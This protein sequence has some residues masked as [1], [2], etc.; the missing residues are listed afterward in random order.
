MDVNTPEE[1]PKKEDKKSPEGAGIKKK[2]GWFQKIPGDVLV[3]PTG[4]IL[5]LLAVLIEIGDW[6]PIPLLDQVWEIPFE[7]AFVAILVLAAKVPIKSLI[8]PFIIERIPLISD[9]LPTWF[10]KMFM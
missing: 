7:I 2:S 10:L 6:I 1:T 3:S 4:I 9:I 8:I 5:V